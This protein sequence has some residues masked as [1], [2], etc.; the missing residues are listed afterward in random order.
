MEY[1]WCFHAKRPC[2][3]PSVHLSCVY[4]SAHMYFQC[5]LKDFIETSWALVCQINFSTDLYN[6]IARQ[7]LTWS[8]IRWLLIMTAAD[9]TLIFFFFFVFSIFREAKAW[10]GKF[11]FLWKITHTHAHTHTRAHTC[12]RHTH[13]HTCIRHTHT[14][15]VRI[16]AAS[17]LLYR[18]NLFAILFQ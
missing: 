18:L 11:Y 6:R 10:N 4:M 3:H 5:S 13:T 2:V 1:L 9:D 16:L 15:R 17:I 8:N 12:T 14:H 7:C